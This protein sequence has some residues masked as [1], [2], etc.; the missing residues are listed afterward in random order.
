MRGEAV[1]LMKLGPHP[2]LGTVVLWHHL[3]SYHATLVETKLQ[4]G[5]G[6][7]GEKKK[8]AA[9]ET[10]RTRPVRPFLVMTAAH[11]LTR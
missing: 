3:A 11:T 10:P 1:R 7:D 8:A 6:S 4:A 5:V 2:Y 9:T